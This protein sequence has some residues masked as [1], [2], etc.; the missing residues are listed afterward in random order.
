MRVGIAGRSY[1][2]KGEMSNACHTEPGVPGWLW[3]LGVCGLAL[4]VL[5]VAVLAT[6][7]ALGLADPP[8]AGP[9]LWQMDFKQGAPGWSFYPAPGGQLAPEQGALAASFGGSSSS[10]EAVALTS[11]PEGD[12]TLEVAGAAAEPP[13]DAAYGVVFGWQDETHYAAVLINANG[14]AEAFRRDGPVRI[15]WFEW[16]QWPH[17]LAGAE[18]N[19]IRVDVR[20]SALTVRI[21]DEVLATATA[22]TPGGRLGVIARAG[23]PARVIFSWVRVWSR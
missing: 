9:L 19:R 21:N 20:G 16:Q 1:Q 12:F 8:R 7:L 10:Q 17:I 18:A 3:R 11:A 22:E 23:G 13:S 6:A 15:D 4:A 2:A 14:Y 5:G